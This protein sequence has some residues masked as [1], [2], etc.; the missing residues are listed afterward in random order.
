M[1]ASEQNVQAF[2]AWMQQVG[3]KHSSSMELKIEQGVCA[4]WGV[5]STKPIKDREKLVWIPKSAVSAPLW[6]LG[7]G[8]GLIVAV[9]AEAGLQGSSK[10]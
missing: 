1:Q 7:G 3:I 6:R 10:W 5:R 2:E 9:M 8:L 4:G